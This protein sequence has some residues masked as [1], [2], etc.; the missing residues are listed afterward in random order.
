MH[1]EI[2]TL[3]E[4]TLLLERQISTSLD[5]RPELR[6]AAADAYIAAHALRIAQFMEKESQKRRVNPDA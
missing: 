4:A 5:Y 3:I 1:D 6:R 2:T